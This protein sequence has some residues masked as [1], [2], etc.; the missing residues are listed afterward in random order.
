HCIVARALS[1]SAG[2]AVDWRSDNSAAT[3]AGGR[4]SFSTDGGA[5]W[6]GGNDIHDFMFEEH[7]ASIK[8][9]TTWVEGS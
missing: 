1:G 4:K 7:G 6:G 8:Q 9:G 5:A 3:Y 2:N